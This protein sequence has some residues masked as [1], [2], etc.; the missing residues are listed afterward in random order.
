[1][2]NQKYRDAILGHGLSAK[3]FHIPFL[4]ANPRFELRAIVQRTGDQAS[5]DHPSAVIYRSAAE[6][7]AS[8]EVDLVI[9]STP[10]GSHFELASQALEAG[11]HLSF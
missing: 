2:A 5:K 8:D 3:V 4:Q 10:P 1:M 7:F 9:V 6:A 11:K